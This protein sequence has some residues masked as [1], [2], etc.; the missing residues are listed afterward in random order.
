M[1]KKKSKDIVTATEARQNL[2]GF[3]QQVNDVH[4]PIQITSKKGNAF[5]VSEADWAAIQET[6]YLSSMPK[7]KKAI[8]DGMKE[9]I[10]KCSKTL[11]W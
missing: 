10:N 8:L 4:V 3:I 5:L 2:Y 1:K 7:V 11:N 9:P 6:L